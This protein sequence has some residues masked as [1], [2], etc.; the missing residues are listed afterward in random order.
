TW[1]KRPVGVPRQAYR[2]H[3]AAVR[4]SVRRE[5]HRRFDER[6][7]GGLSSKAGPVTVVIARDNCRGPAR[8]HLLSTLGGRAVPRLV[9]RHLGE[10]AARRLFGVALRLVERNGVVDTAE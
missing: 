5:L 1:G 7:G 8:S 2:G 4:E 9:V 10:A 6:A 3:R